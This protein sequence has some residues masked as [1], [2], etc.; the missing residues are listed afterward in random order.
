M[1]PFYRLMIRSLLQMIVV[2]LVATGCSG[3]IE[4]VLT[5]RP[6]VEPLPLS[7]GVYFSPEFRAY[8]TKCD[9]WFCPEY[10]IGPPSVALF[11][12]L[13]AGLFREVQIIEFEPPISVDLK[14][15]GILAP[16]ITS[17]TY[18]VGGVAQMIYTIRLYDPAGME[19]VAW[20]VSGTSSPEAAFLGGPAL[21]LA[22]RDAGAKFVKGIGQE[23]LIKAWLKRA[24]VEAIEAVPKLTNPEGDVG[25]PP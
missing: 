20:E 8:R 6:L 7:V 1:F 9:A 13:L 24:G 17:A 11:E 4:P 12:M 2:S 25:V 10:D 22:M 16:A 3:Q 19:V 15:D 23:P 14:I 5:R 18:Q 21:R